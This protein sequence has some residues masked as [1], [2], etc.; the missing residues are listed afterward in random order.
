MIVFDTST[1]VLLAK[2][3]LLDAFLADYRG[4]VVIPQEV[5]EEATAKKT[6]DGLLIGKR[7][8]EGK[9][10]IVLAQRDIAELLMRDFNI[11]LGE[12][13]A[14]AI[15]KEKGTLLATDDKNAIKA[16]KVLKISIATAI[17]FV[18]RSSEKRLI[19]KEAALAKIGLLALHGRY[20]R[21]IISDAEQEVSGGKNAKDVK[22][23][24]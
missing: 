24:N 21:K 2:V 13:E 3:E 9:I 22:R 17:D 4:K 7:I 16:C 20:S 6:F 19:S 14:V 18:L 1:L 10:E 23:E 5:E 15:A 8:E 12:A 11:G